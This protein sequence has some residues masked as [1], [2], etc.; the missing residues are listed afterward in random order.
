VEQAFPR[1]IV[2]ETERK[3]WSAAE[4][5]EYL[6]ITNRAYVPRL[7]EGLHELETKRVARADPTAMNFNARLLAR[8]LEPPSRLKLPTRGVSALGRNQHR[9]NRESF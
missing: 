7:D 6:N 9:R 8:W 5:V 2:A 3:A 1:A 4:C